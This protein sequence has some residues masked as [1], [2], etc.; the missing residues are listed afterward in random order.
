[1][2]PAR[3][4]FAEHPDAMDEVRKAT[5]AY[6]I[7]HPRLHPGAHNFASCLPESTCLW[8][9]RSRLQVRWDDLPAECQNRP[10]M[11]AIAPTIEGEE[12]K[13]WALLA[14]AERE[15]P[16]L[17]LKGLTLADLHRTH[18]FDPDTVAAIVPVST[19][20]LAQYERQMQEER[21]LSRRNS[22]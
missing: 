6:H 5:F 8:C 20:M 10:E 9:D 22:R 17:L 7:N 11:P 4:Y 3:T 19:A 15:V 14:R 2:T 21:E 16:E 12:R 1:M 13:A 18:G